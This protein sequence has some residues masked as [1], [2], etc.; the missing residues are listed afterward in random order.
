ME[1][2]LSLTDGGI[3]DIVSDQDYSSGGCDTCDY[4]AEYVSEYDFKLTTGTICIR[5]SSSYDY[6][7]SEGYMM[8][9]MLSNANFIST[10]SE[11]AFYDWL[12]AK[13]ENEIQGIDSIEF[14]PNN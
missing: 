13:L 4:G 6:P 3:V 9:T 12:K 7:L 10:L 14:V 8:K 5:A 1:R 11:K 2:L